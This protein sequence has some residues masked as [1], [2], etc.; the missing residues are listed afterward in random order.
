MRPKS[1]EVV[2][3]CQHKK[4]NIK[5]T[6][7]IVGILGKNGQGKSNLLEAIYY[8]IT[9]KTGPNSTKADIKSWDSPKG[10]TTLV[11]EHGGADYILK[12]NVH[13]TE[14]SLKWKG[15]E[16]S[17]VSEINAFIEENILGLSFDVFREVCMVPQGEFINIIDAHHSRRL[18]FF[19]RLSGVL[20]A[21]VIRGTL[22]EGINKLPVFIDRTEQIDFLSTKIVN[23]CKEI[24]TVQTALQQLTKQLQ[25]DK[26]KLQG[27]YNTLNIE[28]DKEK[29]KQLRILS[30]QMLKLQEDKKVIEDKYNLQEV[31]EVDTIT[32]T[33]YKLS[34]D[35]ISKTA[36]RKK[37]IK[38]QGDIADF[39]KTEPILPDTFNTQT[40]DAIEKYRYDNTSVY[41]LARDKVCPTC[42][43]P[44]NIDNPDKIV[45]EWD[46]KEQVYE[47][48]KAK[49]T[50]H[51]EE[52]ET[53]RATLANYTNKLSLLENTLSIHMSDYT[54]VKDIVFDT[55][56][57][58]IRKKAYAEYT[59]YT[60]SKTAMTEELQTL[61]A[62]YT[63]LTAELTQLSK[64]P[65]CTVEEKEK[66]Q[67]NI[68][69]R[70]RFTN[71]LKTKTGEY[72]KSNTD[73][74]HTEDLLNSYKEERDKNKKINNL[75][76][77]FEKSRDI[78]HR[79]K[80]PKVVM[81]KMLSGINKR[82][83]KYLSSFNTTFTAQLSEDFDFVCMF[84]GDD[85]YRPAKA[86]SG[87]QKVAL[88]L[89][90]RFALSDAMGTSIPMFLMDEPTV[91]L[92][93]EN[94]DAVSEVLKDARKVV[95]KSNYI[96]IA[97]HRDEIIPSLTD[98]IILG[99]DDI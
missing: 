26:P 2:N 50:K 33:E 40:L 83:D 91:F 57:F 90:F 69:N 46:I 82:L 30:E 37:I 42:Q 52:T 77:L 5:F 19:Q 25:E 18:S 34:S 75:R 32:E 63:K 16:L 12:R 61:T 35:A 13:N 48:E 79:E 85:K 99:G 47:Q 43:R 97:T 29:Y 73:L 76:D 3:F 17:K 80:L 56:A 94:I 86:L 20:K 66:A 55:R 54:K 98:S 22:Q 64:A 72:E 14:A 51:Q 41:V 70:E 4:V 39:K 96:F 23:I 89:S 87:G 60:T 24:T 1:L 67:E 38:V 7:G 9:G 6:P 71:R 36:L 11:F 59:V 58:E 93:D 88:G 45:L 10:H 65:S 84:V 44:Y 92:D 27:W 62:D 31:E 8:S 28:T 95:E 74:K 49:Y 78:L 68:T 81:R 21:E 53:Y 15:G